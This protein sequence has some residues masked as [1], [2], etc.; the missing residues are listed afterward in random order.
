MRSNRILARRLSYLIFYSSQQSRIQKPF[1]MKCT[2]LSVQ[3]TQRKY[4]SQRRIIVMLSSIYVVEWNLNSPFGKHFCDVCT[5]AVGTVGTVGTVGNVGTVRT[6]NSSTMGRVRCVLRIS[7]NVYN[8]W[9][10]CIV[11]RTKSLSPCVTA[12]GQTYTTQLHVICQ[13]L[14]CMCR[15]TSTFTVNQILK[16]GIDYHVK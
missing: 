9:H 13:Y 6:T 16:Y 12:L 4:G 11:C 3:S 5:G 1:N 8:T 7:D 14:Q 15:D 2:P 10:I